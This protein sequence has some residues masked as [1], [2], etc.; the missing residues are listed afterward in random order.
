MFVTPKGVIIRHSLALTEPCMNNEA[1]YEALIA[2]LES[3]LELEVKVVCI[4]RDSQLIINQIIGEYKVLKL[5]LIQYHQ[6]VMELM[7]KIPY[8]SIEK[9]TRAV[10][11]EADALAKL[12]KE[13]G[14]PTEPKIHIIVRNRRPLSLCRAEDNTDNNEVIKPE[15]AG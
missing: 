4:F 5:E 1:E 8:V 2:R 10:N 9:V 6:K 12:A 13:L 7:K 3:S 15:E 11:D 14:E